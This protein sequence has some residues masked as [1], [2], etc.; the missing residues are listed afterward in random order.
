MRSLWFRLSAAAALFVSIAL[1]LVWFLLS[2]LF[3]NHVMAQYERELVSVIDT[4]AAN[5][6]SDESG[7]KLASE[8]ADP[9]YSVPAGGRYWQIW[10][11]GS[12][13]L[14]S[15]S[16]WDTEIKYSEQ[17]EGYDHLTAIEGPSGSPILALS[18]KLNIEGSKG[19][20]DVI[21]TAA[22]DKADMDAALASFS[23]SLVTMLALTAVLLLSAL[24]L[25]VFF[26][27]RPLDELRDAVARI[28]TGGA[29]KIDDTGPSE[30]R[31]LVSEINTLLLGERAAVERAKARASDLAHGLKTP[32]T[33]LGQIGETLAGK[34]E[35]E[36]A[37]QIL[38]QV[39]LIRSRIDRQLAL[40]RIAATGKERVEAKGIVDKLLS[41][42][43]QMPSQQPLNWQA[44]IPP[45][46]AAAVDA[47]DF[48]EAV[49]N[50]LDN[51]RLHA[52]SD[53]LVT[54]AQDGT[55]LCLTVED[56][57][58]GIAVADYGRVMAR[59]QRLD[60]SSEGTGLGLAITS[61][62]LR[63]YGGALSLDRAAIGGLKVTMEWP[64][65]R[66]AIG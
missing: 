40:A 20:L 1:I 61:D 45:R 18:Q 23:R 55:S 28:R 13:L 41:A 22:A 42:M 60:E 29:S 14:R 15:R 6:D 19:A 50:V 38:D 54:G 57:G 30:V 24:G 12:P 21:V 37:D 44:N 32:L 51:A 59:G 62:I 35:A 8:P 9:R 10:L 63:A 47:G 26:G 11:K 66:A 52:K 2:R 4:L 34:R 43:R 46:L 58:K 25:Q 3:E 48:A 65:A 53:I 36:A 31:P 33:V 27:L 16:L 56:D 17:D 39:S 64:L 7:L 49:G 5:L